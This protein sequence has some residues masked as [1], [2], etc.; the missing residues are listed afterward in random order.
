MRAGILVIGSLLWDTNPVR[1]QW[2]ETR[3]AS[4]R[5]GDRSY[6]IWSQVTL[7]RRQLHDGVFP[8]VPFGPREAGSLPERHIVCAGFG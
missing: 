8:L 1:H 2:R 3:L 4:N 5:S 7:T 6:S